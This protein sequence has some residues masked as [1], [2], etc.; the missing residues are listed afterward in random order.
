[1]DGQSPLRGSEERGA[2]S[3]PENDRGLHALDKDDCLERSA[4]RLMLLNQLPHSLMNCHKASGLEQIRRVLDRPVFKRGHFISSS[5]DD[6]IA[7]AAQRRINGQDATGIRERRSRR[8]LEIE[9]AARFQFR[10]HFHR[11]NGNS[12]QRQGECRVRELHTEP[13][14][15]QADQLSAPL[16][17]FRILPC[18]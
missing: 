4:V 6:R 14:S 1:M 12:D 13:G 18:E 16:L 11:P 17:Q 10:D 7:G 3:R 8:H 5:L 2:A 15:F 9:Q